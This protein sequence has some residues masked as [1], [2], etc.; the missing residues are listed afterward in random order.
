MTV[1]VVSDA[2]PL[3]CEDMKRVPREAKDSLNNDLIARGNV[4]VECEL[5]EEVVTHQELGEALSDTEV[6][7]VRC[8]DVAVRAVRTEL[9]VKLEEVEKRLSGSFGSQLED[10]R[11]LLEV[12]RPVE[13]CVACTQ[14]DQRLLDVKTADASF[15]EKVKQTVAELAS[16]FN[17]QWHEHI[18]PC[19]A[20]W[21]NLLSQ[22]SCLAPSERKVSCDG[23]SGT[24]ASPSPTGLFLN[25]AGFHFPGWPRHLEDNTVAVAQTA[26]DVEN[27]AVARLDITRRHFG[28]WAPCSSKG[29]I[30]GYCILACNAFNWL[31][32]VRRLNGPL[33]M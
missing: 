32:W 21:P 24:T 22:V 26:G 3:Y 15:S 19:Y 18:E 23:I 10:M 12:P 7:L 13:T 20:Q 14:A 11:L 29:R 25:I 16:R 4:E 9:R 6:R 5:E 1:D 27:L 17:D 31:L 28:T 8:L 2:Y 30:T 33:R